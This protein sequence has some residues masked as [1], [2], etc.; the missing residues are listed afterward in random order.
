MQLST[1]QSAMQCHFFFL[2]MKNEVIIS[3]DFGAD[4]VLEPSSLS[5]DGCLFLVHC[6][7]SLLFPLEL[8]IIF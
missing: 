4:H 5:D 1:A 2:N 3:E 8:I 6:L 7:L